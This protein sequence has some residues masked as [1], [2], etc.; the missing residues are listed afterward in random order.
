MPYLE[1]LFGN[2]WHWLGLVILVRSIFGFGF[3]RAF[4]S[5]FGKGL[6]SKKAN[7]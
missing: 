5:G 6:V 3:I 1:F 2:F 7:S 4:A